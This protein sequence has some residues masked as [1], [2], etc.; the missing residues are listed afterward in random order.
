MSVVTATTAA[1]AV[2][3]FC[4]TTGSYDLTGDF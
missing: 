1:W 2:A 4:P 3:G